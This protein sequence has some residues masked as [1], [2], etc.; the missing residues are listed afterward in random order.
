MSNN[1]LPDPL[2][3]NVVSPDP[4]P[5]AIKEQE[6]FQTT[7]FGELRSERGS[8]IT[9]ISARYTLLDKVLTV[10]DSLG[11]GS[12]SVVDDKF[13]SQTGTGS[14]GLASILT[15]R[16]VSARPGQGVMA[17]FDAIFTAGVAN[18]QQAAGLITSENSYVFAFVGT[19]FG[20]V[21]THG[22]VSE[23]QELTITTPASGS[24]TATINIDGIP[25]SVPLT[26]G[27]VQHNALEIAESLESQVTNYNF[28]SNDDQVVAQAL[29]AEPQGSFTFSSATAIAAW[30][31]EHAG[32]SPIFDFISQANWSADTRLTGTGSDILDPTKGNFYQIQLCSNFGT[33][34]FFL[35]D[36][37]TGDI[38]LV[39][40]I[41][42]ANLT[43]TT[44]VTNPTYRLGWLAQNLGST[45]NLTCSG[46][47]A[48]AFIEGSIRRNNAPRSDSNNQL[49]VGTSLT[50]I[51]S[52]RNRI[53]FGGKVN[54][55][56]VYPQLLSLS[57]QANKSTF[58]VLLVNPVFAADV[59]FFYIDKTGSVM[60]AAID[61]VGVSGGNEVGS[62]TV[63]PNGGVNLTFNQEL[64]QDTIILP[65][66][67]F[68]IAAFAASGAGG[69]MQQTFTWQEDSL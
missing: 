14:D 20:I 22:G 52:F 53:H 69:D 40:Q 12:N 9:Q 18:S 64:N 34:R 48:S 35:E 36:S 17:R 66:Q 67:T 51:M 21:H 31:Q 63:S 6:P 62:I 59:D 61:S 47:E 10:T 26:A 3:V 56:E 23:T 7:A 55:V 8:S 54:R 38:V 32:V 46:S 60:E 4:L 45:I 44:A 16:Q 58:F 30:F 28:T 65:G 57:A 2:N 24:E 25:F 50:N 15:L 68:T 39:H 29:L 19:A 11:S 5:V 27:T 43:T 1:V 49:S 37:A 41:A 33:A 42:G 13:T